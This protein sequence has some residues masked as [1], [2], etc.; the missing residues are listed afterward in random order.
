MATGF[1]HNA[2]VGFADESTYGTYVPATAFLEIMEESFKGS[3]SK[4]AKPQLRNISVLNTVSSKKS[5]GGGFKFQFPLTGAEKL[6]KHALGTVADTGAG[7]YTHTYTGADAL[8][9]GLSFH[10]NRDAATVGAGSAFKYF[11]AQISKLTFSQKIEDFLMCE[12]EIA[13]Q[14]W[15]N[16]AVETPTFP[17]FS[18]LDWAMLGTFTVGGSTFA[19]DD[20]ELSIE[21][22]LATDRYKLNS[23]IVKGLG[24]SGPRKITGKFTKEFETLAQYAL[25]TNQTNSAI[26]ATWTSSTHS[27]SLSLPKCY[28]QDADPATSEAGPIKQTFTF[29]AFRSSTAGDELSIVLVNGTASG[30]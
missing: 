5:V 4:I 17:T 28:I 23:R 11:G 7:P 12:V 20:F 15:A 6:L 24:R 3:Q 18:G 21:N 19:I 1:G 13:G 9:T 26:V 2:W 30:S 14:D 16:M 8:P 25:F 29:E 10:V 22:T 27:L